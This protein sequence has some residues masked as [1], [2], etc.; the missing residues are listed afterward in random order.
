MIWILFLLVVSVM[1]FVCFIKAVI[2]W[3]RGDSSDRER[4]DP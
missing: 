3:F 4:R 1:L 2:R